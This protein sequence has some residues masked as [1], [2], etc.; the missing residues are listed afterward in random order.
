MKGLFLPAQEL[1]APEE[2]DNH[3]SCEK[4]DDH[5]SEYT[6]RDRSER[7]APGT[8]GKGSSFFLERFEFH[9]DQ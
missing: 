7:A 3:C 4:R 8:P 6:G 2:Q 9:F 1:N 5:T